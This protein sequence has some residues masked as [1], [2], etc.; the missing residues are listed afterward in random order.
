MKIRFRGGG[1]FKIFFGRC[2]E[3]ISER[4]FT[5]QHKQFLQANDN[6]GHGIELHTKNIR[7]STEH[8]DYQ[9]NTQD[10]DGW[11]RG[12]ESHLYLQTIMF[13]HWLAILKGV[14]KTQFL[15]F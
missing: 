7:S 6:Y 1:R 12:I 3:F 2:M 5:K 15:C 14:W 9:T 10:H 8:Q 11:G 4:S 13:L